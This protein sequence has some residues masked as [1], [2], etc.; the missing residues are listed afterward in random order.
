MLGYRGKLWMGY[1][2]LVFLTLLAGAWGLSVVSRNQAAMR[3]ILRENC[4]SVTACRNMNEVAGRMTTALVEGGR[5]VDT[6]KSSALSMDLETFDR[7][8]R[9]QKGN[10]TLPGEAELTV[11]VSDAWGRFSDTYLTLAEATQPEDEYRSAVASK[12]LPALK[13]IQ[14]AT[15]GIM[16]LNLRNIVSVE[17]EVSQLGDEIRLRLWLVQIAAL[18]TGVSLALAVG[19]SVQ[20]PIRRLTRALDE[21]VGGNLE[22]EVEVK[23]KDDIGRLGLAFNRFVSAQRAFQALGWTRM[24]RVLDAAR[25]ALDHVPDAVAI[26]DEKGELLFSNKAAQSIFQLGRVS[27]IQEAEDPWLKEVYDLV[28]RTG[29]AM[30][31][32]AENTIV[33]LVDGRERRFVPVVLPIKGADGVL[34][35]AIIALVPEASFAS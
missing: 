20:R 13:E 33:K 5:T 34:S 24:R 4:D 9:F 26:V 31:G 10:V 11:R 28:K 18:V 17:G 8:L 23:A 3:L 2:A 30:A 25:L 29:S 16:D 1:G 19:R 7:N 21:V 35:E 32:S 12:L 27:S 22:V 6:L 15:H 14:Q